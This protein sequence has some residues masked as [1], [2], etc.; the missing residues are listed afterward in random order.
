MWKRFIS[1]LA[2]AIPT[3]SFHLQS[4]LCKIT[5][6]QSKR[7][8]YLKFSL[9]FFSH[10][11]FSYYVMD[12]FLIWQIQYRISNREKCDVTLPWQQIFWI[13]TIGSSRCN[14]DCHGNENDRKRFIKGIHCILAKE[15]LCTCITLFCSC[16]CTTE[17]WN[18]LILRAHFMELVSTTQQFSFSFSKHRYGPFGFNPRKFHQH[19]SNWMKLN[20][21]DEILNST[22]SLF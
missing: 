5:D 14:D 1:A 22:N 11:S 15:Q 2:K 21:I 9:P 19:L 20:K 8:R 18:F 3:R 6:N 7:Q 13:P 4:S 12:T 17:T 10:F 16:R